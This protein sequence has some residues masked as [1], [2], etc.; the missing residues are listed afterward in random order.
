MRTELDTWEECFMR[1][2][3]EAKGGEESASREVKE[4]LKGG[5][6]NSRGGGGGGGSKEEVIRERLP[7]YG[8]R[9]KEAWRGLSPD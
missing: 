2:G 4:I 7:R 8:A 6:P 3:K 5:D 1:F 9:E